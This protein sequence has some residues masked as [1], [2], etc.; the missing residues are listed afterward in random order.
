MARTR[1]TKKPYTPR[2]VSSEF[3]ARLA[4]GDLPMG[5]AE[6]RTLQLRLSAAVTAFL[7]GK[8]TRE[9]WGLLV[10]AFNTAAALCETAG[11]GQIGLDILYAAQDAMINVAERHIHTNKL[12]LSGDELARVNDGLDLFEQL[13]AIVTK[14]QYLR[15]KDEVYRRMA[16]GRVV[17]IKRTGTPRLSTAGLP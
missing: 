16:A 7:Q 12:G 8:A 11:N 14:R 13:I 1:R 5:E 3:V 9:D 6:R 17:K 2:P 10:G 4:E 15:A